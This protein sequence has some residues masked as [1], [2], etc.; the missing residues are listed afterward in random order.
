MDFVR[1]RAVESARARVA[2]GMTLNLVEKRV[3]AMLVAS[4]CEGASV[5]IE[6]APGDDRAATGGDP[7]V[8]ANIIPC[9]DVL[10]TRR[11][12]AGRHD[13]APAWSRRCADRWPPS[14]RSRDRVPRHRAAR[15]L[16]PA[17]RRER[18][19]VRASQHRRVAALTAPP[20]ISSPVSSCA[21]STA[22]R[23]CCAPREYI[24]RTRGARGQGLAHGG[25]LTTHIDASAVYGGA[26]E[27]A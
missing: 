5:E 9:P 10:A 12:T 24:M 27:M 6:R 11:E 8:V 13:A 14:Q 26:Q 25:L 2:R 22:R 7:A 17:V 20:R 15:R 19:P 16:R 1:Q 3:G 18:L 21:L 4:G 23:A